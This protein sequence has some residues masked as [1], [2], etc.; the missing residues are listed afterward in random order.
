MIQNATAVADV[1][2]TGSVPVP[3]D[4]V[5]PF[6]G[7]QTDAIV[8]GC[9]DSRFLHAIDLFLADIGVLNP[10][11]ILVP[12]SVKAISLNVA[13]V[14]DW[15][16]LRRQ[17]ELISSRNAH[18]PRVI[19]FAHEDC[20]SYE[21]SAHLF[22]GLLRVPGLG[23]KRV[24]FLHENLKI[25]SPADLKAAAVKGRLAWRAEPGAVSRRRSAARR[26]RQPRGRRRA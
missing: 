17:I 13:F 14:K 9:A 5:Y 10:A 25:D 20:R 16:V 11:K 6:H 7:E 24:K 21:H 1:A 4:K 12:G 23:P 19:L 22:G 2:N 3:T 8:L 15:N 18:V 26:R